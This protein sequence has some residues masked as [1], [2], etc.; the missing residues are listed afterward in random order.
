MERES[1]MHGDYAEEATDPLAK[2]LKIAGVPAQERPAPDYTTGDLEPTDEGVLGTLGGG[3]IGMALGGP[4]GGIIGAGLGQHAT[5]GGSSLVE[6]DE[7]ETDEGVLGAALGGIAGATLGGPAGAVRG[8]MAGN[9]IDNLINKDETTETIDPTNPRDY[10]IPA[11]QRKQ[12]GQAP[13]TR[14]DIEQKDRKAEFDYHRRAHGEPHPDSVSD[15]SRSPLAGQ[16]GH[17]GKM[18]EIGKDTS[19]LDRLKE[20]SG[21][22]K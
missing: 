13:L 16:Y 11:I 9:T 17:S 2:I 10:E 12:A 1:V 19:F 21:M 22:K 18:K 3:A 4:I 14:K 5:S 15:E 7:E 20:L 6:K 8:A